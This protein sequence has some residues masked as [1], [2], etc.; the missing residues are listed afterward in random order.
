[1]Q[2]L[3]FYPLQLAAWNNVHVNIYIYITVHIMKTL[4]RYHVLYK[5]VKTL[6]A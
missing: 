2:S 5:I 4:L 6:L 1:M 3:S